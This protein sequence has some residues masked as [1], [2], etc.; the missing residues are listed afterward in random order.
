MSLEENEREFFAPE[1]G[2]LAKMLREFVDSK[3]DTDKWDAI[4]LQMQD[5]FAYF[6]K[7]LSSLK[8]DGNCWKRV[9]E[10][11]SLCT[12]GNEYEKED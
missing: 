12:A 9:K 8:K 5:G 11:Q 2:K 3:K 7:P 6:N 1:F 4:F 10:I